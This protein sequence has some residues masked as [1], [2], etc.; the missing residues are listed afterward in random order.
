MGVSFLLRF[1]AVNLANFVFDTQDLS[2]IRGG[3]LLM[4][5]SADRLVKQFPQ[6]TRIYTGASTGIVKFHADDTTAAEAMRTDVI[7]W[8]HGQDDLRHATFVVDLVPM[9]QEADDFGL[10]RAQLLAKNHWRQ[11]R[12]PS[13]SP[14][15]LWRGE[16]ATECAY[17]LV[18]PANSEIHG[19]EGQVDVSA[20]V[21]SRRAYGR[22]MKQLFYRNNAASGDLSFARSFDELTTLRYPG[23]APEDSAFPLLHHKMAVI[24]IDGNKFGQIQH[25]HCPREDQQ[26]DWSNHLKKCQRQFLTGFLSDPCEAAYWNV[27][28]DDGVSRFRLE[29]LLWG[30]D[31]MI[32]VVPAW[33]GWTFL[34]RFFATAQDWQV[35]DAIEVPETDGRLTHAAAIVFCHH[36]APIHRITALARRL[37]DS[38]KAD[39]PMTNSFAV[40]VLESF[41]HIGRDLASYRRECGLGDAA[42][43]VLDGSR[44]VDIAEKVG[45][46]KKNETD[47]PRCKLHTLV[48][49]LTSAYQAE[50][51][52]AK[53][54][55]TKK[56]D[57]LANGLVA[58]LGSQAQEACRDLSEWM[59]GPHVNWLQL[60]Q[61]W[62]YVVN[63]R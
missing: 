60:S 62:D 37:A 42:S 16:A 29:T 26:S 6:L 32:F 7:D 47:F 33:H 41:D 61:L 63:A 54:I 48:R 44:M 15:D 21:K 1:E 59:G 18:R 20:S 11:M 8:L 38:V 22:D 25:D 4:L 51:E 49:L 55:A 17:D 2:V 50:G 19:P 3:G 43:L 30:G 58:S 28:G 52:E 31:E 39:R 36:N 12:Q 34:Q 13:L 53:D 35:P 9:P 23:H 14:V 5:D 27:T 57:D 56:A 24:Y 40:E 45:L 10:A 46:L